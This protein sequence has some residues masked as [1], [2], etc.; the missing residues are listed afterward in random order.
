MEKSGESDDTMDQDGKPL[1][2]MTEKQILENNGS[3]AG[4]TS[5]E[6]RVTA[7]Q[8]VSNFDPY[9]NLRQNE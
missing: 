8:P 1:H 2:A 3:L 5:Q 4:P 7:V 9:V 6:G